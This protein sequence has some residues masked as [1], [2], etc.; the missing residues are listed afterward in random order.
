MTVVTV[1][2]LRN[3]GGAVLDRVEHGESIVVTR[4]GRAVAEL[5]PV[6]GEGVA[7]ELLFERWR[8]AP[9]VDPAAFRR[10]VDDVMDASL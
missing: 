2:D 1:R 6:V 3:H 9:S 4:D 10:D 7:A 8:N 5:R